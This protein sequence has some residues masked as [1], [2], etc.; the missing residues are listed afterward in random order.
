MIGFSLFLYPR[1]KRKTYSISYNA[2][3]DWSNHNRNRLT[4]TMSFC[5]KIIIRN[6]NQWPTRTM[7][8][9]I[10][11]PRARRREETKKKTGEERKKAEWSSSLIIMR[12]SV[13][14]NFLSYPRFIRY[15]VSLRKD[16]SSWGL[17]N[18]LLL[19]LLLLSVR[20]CM[21]AR[22]RERE[23]ETEAW[24][25]A[26]SSMVTLI[27]KRYVNLGASEWANRIGVKNVNTWVIGKIRKIH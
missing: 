7:T 9:R 19:L 15:C 1:K 4:N 5:K 17:K 16:V 26:P 6:L 2:H 10:I 12:P 3:A 18:E 20:K 8:S 24:K 14:P 23:R 25:I 22:E 27:S 11:I 13:Y 21:R